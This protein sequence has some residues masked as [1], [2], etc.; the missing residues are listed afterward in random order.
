MN[1]DQDHPCIV[2]TVTPEPEEI[3]DLNKYWLD[4]DFIIKRKMHEIENSTYYGCA[5]PFHYIDHGANAMA[6]VLGCPLKFIDAQTIWAYP[7]YDSI[8]EVLSLEFNAQN[9]VYTHIKTVTQ[10]SV[11]KAHFHHHVAMFALDGMTDVL[12]ALYGLEYFLMDLI[13]RPDKVKEAFTHI[14]KIWIHVHEEMSELIAEAKNPG[15]IGWPGIWAPGATFPFQ[16]DVAYNISSEMFKEFCL[17][18]LREQM[19]LIDYPFFH[20]DGV[21]MIAHLDALLEIDKLKVIQWQPGAGKEKLSQWYGLLQKMLSAGKSVQVYARCEEIDDLVKQVG[22]R[23]LL[24][25]ITDPT[26]EKMRS[27]MRR[28]PQN[29]I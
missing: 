2:G 11:E 6:G 18:I 26:H 22:S 24:A 5:V 25:V 28:Y 23:G 14:K 4:S 7:L 27:L 16:E 10:R 8:E 17:P 1:G 13:T 9:P 12:A 21:G 19:E 20:L 29:D 3:E 15:G